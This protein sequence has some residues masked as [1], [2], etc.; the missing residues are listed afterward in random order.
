MPATVTFLQSKIYAVGG[1]DAKDV[2][3]NTITDDTA[4]GQKQHR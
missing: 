1:S 3:M 2:I 4:R